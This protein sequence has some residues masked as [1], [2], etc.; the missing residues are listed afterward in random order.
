M[1]GHGE[2]EVGNLETA[3]GLGAVAAAL[4]DDNIEI[5]PLFLAAAERFPT[6]PRRSSS[7]DPSG[8]LIPH[9]LDALRSYLAQGGRLLALLNPGPDLGLGPL[10]SDYNLAVDDT[11][12]VDREEIAFLGARLGLDPII[13]E[14]P[15]HPITRGSSSASASPRRARSRSRSRAGCPAS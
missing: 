3:E 5:L 8:A 7:R 2:P 9:E 13:E 4:K 15:P 6:M 14:F 1:T 12:I 10:L 11:M